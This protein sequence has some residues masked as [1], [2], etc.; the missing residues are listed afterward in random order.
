MDSWQSGD[1]DVAGVRLHYTRT[2]GAKPPLVMAHGVTD[3]G[4]CWAPIA[5]VLADG[6]DVIM[7]D[8]RGHG[9]SAAPTSGYDPVTQAGDLAGVI[10]GL[11]LHKPIVLGHSMGAMT[12]LMLAGHY[13]DLPGAIILEDPPGQWLPASD[14]SA[15]DGE[16]MA[17]LLAWFTSVK[18][19]T[20]E[21]LLAEQRAAPITWPEAELG[22]WA[23]AKIQFSE[24]IMRIF[25]SRGGNMIDWQT[26]LRQIRCPALLLT[27][28]VER[29]AVLTDAGVAM[30]RSLVPQL[31]VSYIAG[32]G[33][34]IRREQPQQ[35]LSAVG[36]FLAGVR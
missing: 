11:G 14:V 6:Y 5:G 23:D 4:L 26:P 3:S 30:L 17:G 29:G 34:N 10:I 8:A 28:D 21:E 24:H 12:T 22:P 32:A 31:Q 19:K 18:Q 9:H 25:D 36:G 13:A 35:F 33:H 2:G 20:R 16:R 27:A 1:V 7:V 15:A